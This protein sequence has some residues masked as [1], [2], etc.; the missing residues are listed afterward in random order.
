M[1]EGY[2]VLPLSPYPLGVRREG[3][4]ILVSM[5]SDESDCGIILYDTENEEMESLKI[6]FPESLRIGHI[7]AMR[8]EG[9][10]MCYNGYR[11]YQGNKIFPDEYGRCY[12][13]KAYGVPIFQSEMM[14]LLEQQSF[15]WNGDKKPE[16]AFSDAVFYG[17]HVRGFTMGEGSDCNHKGTFAGVKEKLDYLKNLGVTSLLLMP[18]YEF[19]ENER[20]QPIATG[21]GNLLQPR[22]ALNTLNYWGYKKGYYYAPKASYAAGQDPC[23]EMKQLVRGCHEKGIELFMQFYFSEDI[24]ETEIVRVFQYWVMEYHVDGFRVMSLAHININL[25]KNEPLLAETKIIYED[26]EDKAYQGMAFTQKNNK[27]LCIYRDDTMRDYRR[28]LRGEEDTLSGVKYHFRK[29]DSKIAFLNSIA[30]Y[31]T[32]RIADMVSYSRKH[33]EANG[34]YNKDGSSYNYSWNCGVEGTTADNTVLQLRIRQIKNAL[35]L[36]FLSQGTPYLF[37]GDEMGASQFG[38][39]NP[40]NQDNEISWLNWQNLEKNKEIY[41]FVKLLIA[42]RKKHKILHMDSCLTGTDRMGYGVADIS[43]HGLQVYKAG[44]EPYCREQ[45]IMLCDKYAIGNKGCDDISQKFIYIAFNMY[46]ESQCFEL[47]Q[48]KK[49]TGNEGSWQVAFHT[50]KEKV[51]VRVK[52]WQAAYGKKENTDLKQECI[53]VPPRTIVVLEC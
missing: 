31:N 33:N 22:T 42:Y 26:F 10:P 4:D 43:F 27:R 35:S 21:P 39:N 13:R 41:D 17:L 25:I 5:I 20:S 46:W 47:P 44:Q 14:G 7:Y 36:I 15:D 16:V 19:I 12:V 2:K 9:I 29:N 45:G 3:S 18:A 50:S 40:Y 48:L 34:E 32:L 38:N 11:V 30:D 24:P 28:F 1:A 37:M 52:Q 8:L 6:S 53:V 51:E 23:T 49:E